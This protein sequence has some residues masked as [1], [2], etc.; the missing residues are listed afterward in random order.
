MEVLVLTD[1]KPVNMVQI[2]QE[3]GSN[4]LI[5][6]GVYYAPEVTLNI[7]S[8]E[9]LEKQGFSVGYD[10][11]RCNLFLMF[12]DRKIH[13]FDQDK[14]R[15]MQNQYLQDYFESIAS[16][17]GMEQEIVRFKGNLYSTKAHTGALL[18]PALKAEIENGSLGIHQWKTGEHGANWTRSAVPKGKEHHIQVLP[19]MTS[20]IP[21][22][23]RGPRIHRSSPLSQNKNWH[24][25][26]TLENLRREQELAFIQ[27]K[28][29]RENQEKLEVTLDI[30]SLELLE[31]QG[32]SVGY[33]GNRY[34]L[35]PMFKDR[36][37][38]HFDEDKIRKMQNQY[39]QDYFESIASKEGMEREI[40][41]I[42]GNLYSTKVQTFNDFVTFLNLIKHDEIVSQEWDYFR[43]RFNKLV[44]WFFNHYLE[45]SLYDT[46]QPTVNGVEIHLFDLYKIFENLGGY[47]SFHFSQ[48]FDKVGEIIGLP[49]GNG[50]KIRR[51]YMNFLEILTSHF[52]TARAPSKA[53]TGALLEPTLKEK[54][55]NGSLGEVLIEQGSN[56]LI[57]PG[58]Y[59]APEVTLN[60]LS[61][62]LLEKQGFSVGY[63]GNR[64][65]L[66]PMFKDKKIHHFDED[67]MRKMQN[68]Y[69]QNY[70]ESIASKEGMEQEI[71][72]IKGNLYS[73]KKQGF[74]VG[75]DG[76]R[77][78]LFPMFKDRKIHHF[79][80]DKIRKMQNQY[81]QDYFE[82]IA[83]KEGM[84]QEI[85]RIKG[86]LYS[87]KVQTLNDSVTFL[88]LIK[89]D[90]IVSQE[91]DY[92]RNRFNKLVKWFF[93]HYLER[94]LHD[95]IPPTVNG[96]KIYLFD[97]Y[98]IIENL[99][100]YLSVHF[101]QEFDKVGEI[102]GQPKGN[103]EKIKRSYMN[104]LEILT[105]HFKTARAPSK[106]HTGAL[107]EPAL[108]AKIDNGS[109][110]IHQWK[111][112]EHNANWTRSA[113][114]KGKEVIE[115]FGVQLEDTTNRTNPRTLYRKSTEV[116]HSP[117]I[118]KNQGRTCLKHK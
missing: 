99:G 27:R 20:Y 23:I 31:K 25:S 97:L 19:I 93:N 101:S 118:N 88:N 62:E 11:N 73:T 78:N 13:H 85:V 68:Q 61:L 1:G 40:V 50:E 4:N 56:N 34:N 110:G 14:M 42:K 33:D 15:K 9:L 116:L 65:N 35:F 54:I 43:N 111:T 63:D 6:P 49:K 105:S 18:D 113:V 96:V 92:F 44:K 95:T 17:E 22:S 57:I 10:G 59:Y 89:H 48:E 51:C 75:Y 109:L 103:M 37:I 66:F 80:E 12:K 2:G 115:H 45:R 74:S 114:P 117:I 81:L 69:L 64:R 39:L 8:L 3:Q 71:D 55:D 21:Y 60:I 41:R 36:K 32:F 84:E 106:A 28:L 29:K 46:I 90:E 82:S 100:G 102:I 77:C 38:H 70:I 83:S 53:H 5:I 7:L 107:L 79:D 112:G 24:Q 87:T 72:R 30:L 52:K 108:K 104:F 76:I 94:F 26:V 91:W 47:L 58:V 16:K 86:N 98:K 67:K